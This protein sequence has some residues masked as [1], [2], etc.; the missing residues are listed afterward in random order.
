MSDEHSYDKHSYWVRLRECD[1]PPRW[2]HDA[3]TE[4]FRL[5]LAD[6]EPAYDYDAWRCGRCGDDNY[7]GIER[8]LGEPWP[9]PTVQAIIDMDVQSIYSSYCQRGRWGFGCQHLA[10][11]EG[12]H[13]D[14]EGEE[15]TDDEATC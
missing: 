9:C 1:P 11:H 14:S 10:G 5:I 3:V 6:H 7:S 8:F 2:D 13:I 15:W 12:K 4:A